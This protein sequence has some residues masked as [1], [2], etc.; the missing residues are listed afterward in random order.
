MPTDI[1]PA[2]IEVAKPAIPIT[3]DQYA[4]QLSDYWF[5]ASA[6][7]DG[8]LAKAAAIII[9]ATDAKH[10]LL[11]AANATIATLTARIADAD[12]RH[13]EDASIILEFAQRIETLTA[14]AEAAEARNDRWAETAHKLLLEHKQALDAKHEADRCVAELEAAIIRYRDAPAGSESAESDEESA[15]KQVLFDAITPRDGGE[16]G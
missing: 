15:A 12:T 2:E 14:R 9:D 4:R 6:Y 13:A 11:Q 3:P 10:R 7:N 8:F 1:T 5:G 16:H